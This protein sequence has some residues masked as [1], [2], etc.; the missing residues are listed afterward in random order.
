M[1]EVAEVAHFCAQLRRQVVGYTIKYANLPQDKLAFPQLSKE[2]PTVEST[3]SLRDILIGK[4]VK[5]TGRHGKYFWLQFSP[6]DKFPVILLMHMGMTGNIKIEG[7][8]SHM[9]MMENGGDK[10][11]KEELEL[12]NKKPNKVILNDTSQWPP[13]HT[14]FD[15]VF[16]SETDPDDEVK[17]AFI[18]PRRLGRIWVFSDSSCISAERLL[19]R[20][21]LDK[22][23]PDYSKDPNFDKSAVKEYTTGDPDPNP[24]DRPRLGFEAFSK[25]I[26]S[27][28]R[29]I[30]VL[31]LDQN[32]FAGIGNWVADEILYH[33]RLHPNEL[34]STKIKQ[35]TNTLMRKLYDAIIYVMEYCVK[36]EANV[37]EYPKDWLM[38]Y[39][40]GKARKKVQA[41]TKAGLLVKYET[42]NGRTSSYVPELQKFLEIEVVN[43]RR[44]DTAK[45]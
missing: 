1:P 29:A 15:L 33:A 42:V 6:H 8:E 39:R 21:P 45:N 25:L 31:L 23:G 14:R 38:L 9:I 17:V 2:E 43:D 30:K 3:D 19:K 7:V 35:P 22:L 28:K 20:H 41:T 24:H 18:D 5:G 11:A 34:L 10:R 32:L 27:R 12:E 26:L 13:K 36:V 44:N 40:W 16:V 37:K 4:K